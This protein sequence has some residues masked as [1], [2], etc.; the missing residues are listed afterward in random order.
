MYAIYA[1]Q[2][3]DVKDSVSIEMQIEM[4]RKMFDPEVESKVYSDKGYSGK[5]TNRPAF[6]Q[7]MGDL[8]D[9]MIEQIVVYRLDR[10]SRSLL[11]F[12][13]A[14]E[15]MS[16]N[17]V[18]FISVNEKF[19]TSTPMGK[20]MLFIIMVFAQLERETIAE[21]VKDNYYT[22]IK[23]KGSWPGGPAPFGWDNSEMVSEGRK[24]P[25]LIRNKNI[26]LLV[27][28]YSSYAYN[29]DK[30]LGKVAL[31]FANE[32]NERWTNVRVA[33]ILRNPINVKADADIYI[34]YKAKGV[35]IENTIE[36][37]D[38]RHACIL[39]GKRNA[40]DRKRNDL[41][42]ATLVLAAWDGIVD[43]ETW[44]ACQY[45]LE[46][47]KPAAP[48][49][50]SGKYSWLGGMM[51]CGKCGSGL[52]V[53]PY[54]TPSTGE[55]KRLRLYCTGHIDHICDHVVDFDADEVEGYVQPKLEEIFSKCKEEP[56]YKKN[57]QLA[58]STKIELQGI[59]AKIENLIGCIAAGNAEAETIS[60]INKEIKRLNEKKKS[61]NN[62]VLTQNQIIRVERIDFNKLSLE[63]KKMVARTYIEKVIVNEHRTLEIVFKI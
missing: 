14:W 15:K 33:R 63:E 58:N 10:F 30:S 34:Y 23:N 6:N 38:G 16:K 51:K 31:D 22:R 11:D 13:M 47:N 19:D 5:N 59:E 7:L 40:G 44:L 21:R 1:R 2:S 32:T 43:S 36:E 39:V 52:K 17:Q 20:A 55:L 9:G 49:T 27:N 18:D 4:C 12:S 61:L 35:T 54:R 62:R 25:I 48:N 3:L 46:A 56:I 28:A 26:N 29:L 45:R 8:E 37:F 50:G 60:Y 53:Q 57:Q 42:E 41:S 24:I